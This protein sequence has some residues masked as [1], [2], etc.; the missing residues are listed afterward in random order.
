MNSNFREDE[1]TL[2]ERYDKKLNKKVVKKFPVVGGRLRLF[3]ED[4]SA[5]VGSGIASGIEV[6]V[7]KYEDDVAV[8]KAR[9][10]VNGN[11]FTGIGM[12]SR[13]RDSLIYPAILE[14]AETRAIARAL[15]FAGYGV[16]YTG[17][18]EMY[19]VKNV[20]LDYDETSNT[21]EK[22]SV[23]DY[24]EASKTSTETSTQPDEPSLKRQVW[25]SLKSM[26]PKS[27]DTFL[28]EQFKIFV[29]K[30]LSKYDGG[31]EE[32]VFQAILDHKD[33]F[34]KAFE[35]Q[36]MG[37]VDDR[38][39]DG[40]SPEP[41]E[42]VISDEQK[43]EHLKR[44]KDLADAHTVKTQ[45][46]VCKVKKMKAEIY[47]AMPDGMNVKALNETLKH[48]IE[49]NPNETPESIYEISIENI[50]ELV[51]IIKEYCAKIGLETGLEDPVDADDK[52]AEKDVDKP[53]EKPPVTTN[54]MTLFRKSWN[55][56]NWEN[57]NQFVIVN[58][59]TFKANRDEYDAAVAKYDNMKVNNDAADYCFP[60]LF[61]ET[62][63]STKKSILVDDKTKAEPAAL[64]ELETMKQY[65]GYHN[66]IANELSKA[67]GIE[68]D[69][70]DPEE[71]CK[72]NDAMEKLLLENK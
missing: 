4:I 34:K 19:G 12:S 72:F 33:R 56:L 18:E 49:V 1:I 41:V 14:L 47:M 21:E 17:A 35:V 69:T 52:P 16:E 20:D 25:D 67:I 44:M 53:A 71:A 55:R 5:D 24:S 29:N 13:K 64:H 43:Q 70:T 45:P 26:F 58:A 15:R 36:L 11:A 32:T 40:G 63:L 42:N 60:Y 10:C 30:T 51:E 22:Q 7:I 8:I 27:Q 68:L 50:G 6:D 46:V 59:N 65:I 66:D 54:D 2:I 3:H 61:D 23:N 9:V 31:T 37:S 28:A 62:Q 57:F 38:N 48:L 39:N